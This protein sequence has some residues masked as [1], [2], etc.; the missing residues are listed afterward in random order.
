MDNFIDRKDFCIQEKNRNFADK[1]KSVTKD[2]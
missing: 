2:E 1:I